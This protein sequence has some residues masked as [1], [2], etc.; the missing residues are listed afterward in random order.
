MKKIT[1]DKVTAGLLIFFVLWLT[2]G[3]IVCLNIGCV[4]H[5]FP[6]YTPMF[7]IFLLYVFATFFAPFSQIIVNVVF[8]VATLILF[9]FVYKSVFQHKMYANSALCMIFI[10]DMISSLF[11]G[12]VFLAAQQY[13]SDSTKFAMLLNLFGIA[14][15]LG[16][17]I[18]S[19]QRNSA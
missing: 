18:V 17:V 3:S 14:V 8:I 5:E 6:V 10:I 19:V 16:I 15:K 12:L 7:A 1:K 2:V 11:I 9:F 4:N 13:L